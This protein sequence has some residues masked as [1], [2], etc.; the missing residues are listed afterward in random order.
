MSPYRRSPGQIVFLLVCGVI[1]LNLLAGLIQSLVVPI[2]VLAGVA[3][4][5]RLAF[6]H[7]TRRW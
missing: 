1:A 3:V 7:T 2:V 4:I 6:F 5:V